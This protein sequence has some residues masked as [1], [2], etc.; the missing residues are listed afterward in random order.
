MKITSSYQVKLMDH[1]GMLSE[2]VEIYREAVA[3]LI[4]VANKEWDNLAAAYATGP[5]LAQAILGSMVHA[6]KAH[7][8]P[9]YDFDA[10]FYKFPCY[11]RRAAM[12]TAIGAV[13]SYRSSLKNWEANGKKGKQPTLTYKRNVMPT[14]FKGNMS[15]SEKMLIGEQDTVLLKLYCNKDWVFVPI[16]CRHQDVK[17]LAKWW[18]SVTASAPTLEVRHRK[19]RSNVY[20]LRYAFTESRNLSLRDTSLEQRTILAV[21]LGINNDAVCSVMLADGT[22]VARK[23]INFPKEKDRLQHILNRIRRL[24]R[25]HGRTGGKHEWAEARRIN[26]QLACLI[27][28]A[29]V[30]A[31]CEYGVNVIVFEYLNTGG[32][33]RGSKKQRLHLWRKN[34]IQKMVEHKA[35][36]NLIR[37]SRVCAWG[38]SKLAFDGSGEVQRD[39]NNHSLCTFTTGKRYNCDLSASYNIG[40]RYFLREMC[41]LNS[42]LTNELPKTSQR[43]YADLYNL[44]QFP[45]A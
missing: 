32:K 2:T 45:A 26:D 40:A 18:I 39:K 44:K 42:K 1:Q 37:I 28:N 36:R 7:P 19:G 43:T 21:D 29:I 34:D 25:E 14:F 3:F 13:S 33:I 4:D 38:T 15:N 6:T 30:S 16:R 5:H 35:H 8:S 10:R 22:V 17:Y 41:S 24:Q 31:A 12:S 23:F 27:A 11:L 9:K 20:C